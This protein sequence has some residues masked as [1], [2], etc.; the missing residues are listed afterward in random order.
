MDRGIL[1]GVH[2]IDLGDVEYFQTERLV[3]TAPDTTPF[4]LD[5]E[6]AGDAPVDILDYVARITSD[7]TETGR[8]EKTCLMS[9][10]SL[11]AYVMA[12]QQYDRVAG[13]S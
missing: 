11:S 13:H 8:R 10:C 12:C 9:L 4:E 5:G 7:S 1:R 3:C 2:R 6:D